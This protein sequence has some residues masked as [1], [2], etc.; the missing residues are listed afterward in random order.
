MGLSLECGDM[1][2]SVG[3]YSSVQDIRKYL[4]DTI[5]NYINK[6]GIFDDEKKNNLLDKI[7]EVYD[8][9]SINYTK[10]NNFKL[11]YGLDCFGCFISHSDCDGVIL[12]YDAGDFVDLCDKLSD[13]F[14]KENS[15]FYFN[16]KFYLYDIFD[17]SSRTGDDIIFC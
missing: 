10:L 3:S 1:Y 17:Y 15:R 16:N 4:L 5:I 13:Y 9:S 12:S 2:I 7:K 6:S 11:G 8:G 14:D